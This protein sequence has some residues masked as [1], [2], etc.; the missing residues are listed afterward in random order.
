MLPGGGALLSAFAAYTLE[1]KLS[2]TPARFGKGAIEGVAAPEA[3]NNAGAQT[4]FIPL[5]TL[6]I[7]PNAVMA[8]MVGAMMIHGIQPGPQVMTQAARA[9]LGPDRQHVDRQPDAGRHQ[10]A[11]DRH[12]GA[13]AA[14]PYRLLFPAILL[15]C[16]IGVYSAQQQRRSTSGLTALFGLL[17]YF[18]FKLGCEPAP[19]LLGFILGPM[20]E[21]NLRRALLLSHGDAT[22]F[23]T[24][25]ISLGLLV[26]AAAADAC[27]RP[28]GREERAREGFSGVAAA[29]NRPLG[30]WPAGLPCGGRHRL[31]NTGHL[32]GLPG[33]C[34]SN[35]RFWGIV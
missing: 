35:R 4:S 3:A 1:K 14:V 16:C 28:S 24:R 10:P 33:A 8:L 15:F 27:R 11:A 20:M 19:L 22:V 31:L 32:N 6:G 17:G 25:P 7:P 5:L 29:G 18:F 12:L 30:D 9:V 23:V 2:R 13:A 21:E 34:P 26:L